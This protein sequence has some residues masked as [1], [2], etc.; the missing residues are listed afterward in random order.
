MNRYLSIF[1]V[2]VFSF[3]NVLL[4]AQGDASKKDPTGWKKADQLY[5][6]KGYMASAAKYQMKQ[7]A[8]N[9]EPEVMARIANSYRLN[10]DVDLA[11]YWYSKCIFNTKNAEDKL[12]YAEVLQSTGKCE[13]AIR[14]FKEYQKETHSKREFISDCEELSTFKKRENIEIENLKA[15]NTKHLDYSAMS[16]DGGVIF[17][18]TRGVRR[19]SKVT[20]SW[21]K[22]NFSD[23]FFAK[24]NDEGEYEI[25]QPIEGAINKKYHDGVTTITKSGTVMYFSR[26]NSKKSKKGI[27]DLKIYTSTFVDGT[28]QKATELP[29]NGAD[30]ASCHPTISADGKHLYFASNRPGGFG[31]MDIYV[32]ENTDGE[33]SAPKNLGPTVNSAGNEIFPFINDEGVLFFSSNGHKGLGGLDVFYAKKASPY[34]ETTWN[35]RKNLGTPF[36]N[37]KDDF[38]FYANP[39]MT[40]GFLTSNRFGG[41]GGDDIYTWK[42]NDGKPL[43]LDDV[44]E[45]SFK[46]TDISTKNAV[47]NAAVTVTDTQSGK[48][49]FEGETNGKGMFQTVIS[50]G[51]KY[52]VTVEKD[53]YITQEKEM[54]SE[55]LLEDEM[56]NIN[57]EKIKCLEL[58][59]TVL[60]EKYNKAIP[61]TTVTLVN[62]C[63]GEKTVVQTQEDGGFDFCLDTECDFDIIA[64][65]V[66]FVETETKVSTINYA[67]NWRGEELK[68]EMLPAKKVV[69][70]TP[71]VKT[72]TVAT[73]K[74]HLLGNTTADFHV[75]Q[76]LT[77]KNIYY[78]FDKSNIRPDAQVELD[79]V[80]TMMKEI[81]TMEITLLSHTDSKGKATYN[82]LLSERR[83]ASARA[84]IVSKG[85]APNR[86]VSVGKGES[87]LKNEC[88]D[89]VNCSEEKNQINRRTEI[90]INKMD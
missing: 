39:E 82:K 89:G 41:K 6:Q 43:K 47:R 2:T 63:T 75:G 57:L 51:K 33:W 83:A 25:P 45:T 34:D 37:R 65:K 23:V 15:L 20:D 86:I 56:M 81:P 50:E 32:S 80:V 27:I 13:D 74:K 46:V 71:A 69:K 62:K 24:M 40:N 18:S 61:N 73:V 1:F 16:Y 12:H 59:G 78:D 44:V 67:T 8:E 42:T 26:N 9:M 4:F 48:T 64:T 21:T 72:E 55:E 5:Q 53:G 79:Y 58:Y 11:E 87:E 84:Y 85:I 35:V 22:S 19:A 28:W 36:N 17:T 30:F 7:S 66:D 52:K 60:N 68:I 70:S 31:G 90:L 88:K 3:V 76:V 38:G 77:L 29:F 54:T 10:G 14:W 49:V